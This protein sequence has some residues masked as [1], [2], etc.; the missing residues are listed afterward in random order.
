MRRGSLA[1]KL[2][3]QGFER[4][5]LI[6]QPVACGITQDVG[7]ID[8]NLTRLLPEGCNGHGQGG[9]HLLQAENHLP[10]FFVRRVWHKSSRFVTFVRY[11][12]D[13]RT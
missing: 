6:L 9:M 5:D 1:R 8:V 10:D 3:E 7:D 13:D 12:G 4:F 2:I 11:D